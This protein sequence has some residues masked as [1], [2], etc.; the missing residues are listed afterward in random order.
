MVANSVD[1]GRRLVVIIPALNEEATV[2]DVVRGALTLASDWLEVRVLVV[3]DGSTDGTSDVSRAAGA[4]VIDFPVN[5]GLGRAFR[6]GLEG[7]LR[8]RADVIVNIDAD[9]QFNTEDIRELIEPILSGEADFVTAS[10]FLDRELVP[11]MPTVKLYGNHLMSLLVSFIARQRFRD[12]SCGFRAYSRESAL[13]LN[14][15]GR[16]TYTQ[17]SF[18]DMAVKG[19]RIREVAVKVLGVRPVGESR[20]ARNLWNYGWNTGRIIFRS[21]RDYWP[22]PFFSWLSSPFLLSGAVLLVFFFCHYF[23]TGKFSPHL[24]AGFAAGGLAAVGLATLIVGLFADMLK[25]IRLNQEELL[26][27][28]RRRDLGL[29]EHDG[30]A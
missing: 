13:R 22:L 5:Q 1:A 11:V 25:R 2:A 14:L 16:F 15:W 9:G 12:V 30:E 21:Y 8:R 18:L 10:R 23:A 4:D 3:N 20:I 6:A 28:E 19:M 27:L 26:Y 24:W 29:R 7:A 17:E